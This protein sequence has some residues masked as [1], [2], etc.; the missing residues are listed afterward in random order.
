LAESVRPLLLHGIEALARHYEG[1]LLDQFGVLHDG[2]RPFEGVLDA[3]G[4]LKK[5]QRAVI[6]LSNSG[7]RAAPNE[8]RLAGLGIERGLYAELISSGEIAWAGLRSRRGPA[9]A[10]LG[11]HCLYFSR[12]GDRSAIDGLDLQTV[13]DAARAD[14][15]LLTGMDGDPRAHA[16][17]RRQLEIARRR[18]LP[19][20]CT[21]PDL[22]SL[23]GRV[24]VA[25]PGA[26]ASD[27]EKAGGEV[28]WIG[29]PWPLVYRTALERLVLPAAK[30]VAV[31]DSLDHDIDG[32]AAAGLDAALVLAGVHAGD[33]AD[34]RSEEDIGRTVDGLRPPRATRPR[35]VLR[36][37]ALAKEAS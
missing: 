29:K 6:I 25:G 22:V 23:E 7:K 20:V 8:A 17:A 15:V 36:R 13:E 35:W 4:H 16:A 27:Y 2:E 31:G 30:V 34:T 24:R 21:N 12:G 14:F 5:C 33:F 37:F 11:R 19:L 18:G 28:R 26:I 10:D 32:A 1:F 3:L 9:F